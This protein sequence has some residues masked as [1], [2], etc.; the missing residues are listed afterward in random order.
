VI[1]LLLAAFGIAQT[2]FGKRQV[3]AL[4]ESEV[5]DPPTHLEATALEGVVPFNMQLVGLRLSDRQGSG[6]K[7]TAW[8]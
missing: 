5:S 7:P 1:V 6:W 8:R 4:L 3:L 2:G